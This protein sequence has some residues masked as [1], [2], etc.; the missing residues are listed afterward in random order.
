MIDWECSFLLGASVKMESAGNSETSKSESNAAERKDTPTPNSGTTEN[1]A[2]T[3]ATKH[4]AP[5]P[6]AE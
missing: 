5:A 6:S 1:R 2:P 3:E 4:E